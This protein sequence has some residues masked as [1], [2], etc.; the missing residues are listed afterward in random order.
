METNI[1]DF[2]GII[3][4]DMLINLNRNYQQTQDHLSTRKGQA[5]TQSIWFEMDNEFKTFLAE[6][7]NPLRQVSG[8]RVYIGEYD[9]A[10]T[11]SG[12]NPIFYINK[13]TVGFVATK[14]NGQKHIDHPDETTKKTNLAIDA[15]NHG[16]I[17]P[18]DICP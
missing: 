4:Y 3:P 18:P 6:L 12:V 16:K 13:L 2:T 9:K 1:K 7:L 11:P 5:E 14:F 15:Y 8:L 10:T 17:C